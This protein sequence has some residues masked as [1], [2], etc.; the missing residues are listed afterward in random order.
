MP[1][2]DDLQ[3][4]KLEAEIEKIQAEKNK[5]LIEIENLHSPK[6][7]RWDKLQVMSGLLIPLVIAYFAFIQNKSN[8]ENR[9][10]A[11]SIQLKL[12]SLQTDRQIAIS[13]INSRVGQVNLV[14]NFFDAL[15][16]TDQSRKKLAIKAVLIALPEEG[17]DLVRIV[18]SSD[19]K[20][21]IRTYAK[22]S[23]D[24]RRDL[25][26]NQMYSDEPS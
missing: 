11:A 24:T 21:S 14:S 19:D 6:K 23:L 22:T 1:E 16:S 20:D 2:T 15:L 3:K 12:D 7:N 5:V 4:Q 13:K 18:S 8:D 10:D 17:P 25:L 26:I 9:K